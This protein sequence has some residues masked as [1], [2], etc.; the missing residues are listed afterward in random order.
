MELKTFKIQI[1]G[2]VQGVGFRPF[3]YQLAQEF[4]ILGT[5]SNNEQGVVILITTTQSKANHFLDE[6]V[7][8]KPKVSVITSHSINEIELMQFTDFSI[9]KTES[10]Q[11]LNLPLT[12]DFAI[13]DSCKT[14]VLDKKNRR[15]NYPFTTCVHCGPRYSI[16]TKYPF[17]RINTSI[18]KFE[19]CNECLVEYTSPS[20]RRFHSQ[21]NS[22]NSCG[23][24]LELIDN[25]NNQIKSSNLIKEA[26]L[27]LE[28]G[29]IIA[30]KNTNGYLLCCDA[31]NSKAINQ[32]RKRK[33][34]LNKS[35]AV[36]YPTIESVKNDFEISEFE[37]EE[38]K[39]SITPI[40]ILENKKPIIKTENIAPNINQTGVMLPSSTLLFLLLNELKKPIVA[41]S[42]NIHGSPIIYNNL[43][44]F[45][46]LN[47]VADDFLNHNLEIEF[48]QDDSVVKFEGNNR[49]ILR[50]SRGLAP[51]YLKSIINVKKPL[52][53]MG[54]HLKSTF[55][56]V[57]NS[58]IYI[59]QY[60]GNL[61]NY[62]VFLRYD[63]T[64][65]QYFNLFNSKPTTI[66]IDRHLHYQSS[67]LGKELATNIDAEIVEIQHHKAHFC[68]V[69]GEHKLFNSKQKVLGVIWDGTG[70]GDDDQIWGGEF[71]EYEN[72]QINRINHFE[73]YN[74]VANDK[75][76]NEPRLSLLSLL[77]EDHKELIKEKFTPT[78]WKI[79]NK[80][81]NNN[82]LKT[83]SVG[84]LFDAVASALNLI[85]KNSYEA[86]AAILLENCAKEYKGNDQIDF[87]EQLNYTTVPTSLIM[88]IALK[89]LNDGINKSFIASSFIYTL[90]N[91]IVRQATNSKIKTIVCSG[92]VFQN[93]TLIKMLNKL[94]Q[95]NQ[96][97]LKIN[98]NLSPNDENI[99]FGQLMYH[100]N[101]KI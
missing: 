79:Y 8:S 5:V 14:E 33:K 78:E 57:P 42:G 38:L 82:T 6:V 54:A 9:Y 91:T 18:N 98:R 40:V 88:K 1:S 50:R 63:K 43:D 66:L 75:M 23:I 28:S 7:N 24:Q 44:A 93:A 49:V 80:T 32:L 67:I 96:I 19:M 92:G 97:E 61:D 46:K 4:E 59:S 26:A 25:E 31:T 83:S 2:R 12:P 100:Q 70:L 71:F 53:A 17:D 87:L 74:W 22:C 3:I 36:I 60:F 41:T 85:D 65:K 27:L 84:R 20:D 94:C 48:S 81:L 30:I 13:C 101:I 99:S 15:Y 77:D 37:E 56:F 11:E 10:N 35:F 90:A 95:N 47:S 89:S 76:A 34:R 64:I 21:T 68:S 62:D 58:Q 69:L 29:S 16:T 52:L 39:S 55:C 45:E 86:E 51:S 72:N 73:Y